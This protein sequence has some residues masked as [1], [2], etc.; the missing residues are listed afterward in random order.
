MEERRTVAVAEERRIV[1]VE[2]GHNLPEAEERHIDQAAAAAGIDLGAQGNHTGSAEER[3]SPVVHL[4]E[5]PP[6]LPAGVGAHHKAADSLAEEEDSFPVAAG[7]PNLVVEAARY[8]HTGP[9]AEAVD[10]IL[11]GSA[12]AVRILADRTSEYVRW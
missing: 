7:L 1:A 2:A 5:E 3:R 12:A 6:S 4:E 11:L 10:S 8:I 9:G